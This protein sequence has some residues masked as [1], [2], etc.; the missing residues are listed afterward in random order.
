[1]LH[2]SM[3]GEGKLGHKG[4]VKLVENGNKW[5]L[6]LVPICVTVDICWPIP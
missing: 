5:S 1:M 2:I 6:V 4:T 3:S